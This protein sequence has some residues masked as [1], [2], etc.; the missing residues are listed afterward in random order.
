[1]RIQTRTCLAI[2]GLVVALATGSAA[3]AALTV[4]YDVLAA[5]G[6]NGAVAFESGAFNETQNAIDGALQVTDTDGAQSRVVDIVWNGTDPLKITLWKGNVIVLQPGTKIRVVM[7]TKGSGKFVTLTV[8]QGSVSAG[9][10]TIVPKPGGGA[11]EPTLVSGKTVLVDPSVTSYFNAG[12]TEGTIIAA[13]RALQEGGVTPGEQ[14]QIDALL[15]QQKDVRRRQ[16]LAK[17]RISALLGLS[18][19]PHLPPYVPPRIRD[20]PASPAGV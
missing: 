13:I 14:A 2:G 11:S 8:I 4:Q 12:V 3:A 10:Q 9:G 16:K 20:R 19:P 17:A 18:K 1:M 15:A 5:G 7:D 6:E